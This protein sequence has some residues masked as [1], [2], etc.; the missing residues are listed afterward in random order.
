MK[1]KLL[2]RFNGI[3]PGSVIT[4]PDPIAKELISKGAAVLVREEATD[5]QAHDSLNDA[6]ARDQ[7]P[8][9]D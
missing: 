5:K 9:R 8:D 6:K 3:Q 2:D 7:Q 4:V 1:I